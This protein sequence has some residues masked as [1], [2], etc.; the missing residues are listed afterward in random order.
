MDISNNQKERETLQ[1]IIPKQKAL[2][3]VEF[4]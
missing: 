3:F 2:V 4:E 1:R